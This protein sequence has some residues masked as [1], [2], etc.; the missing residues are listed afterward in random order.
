[1]FN[2]WI[3]ISVSCL[4]SICWV[5]NSF[6]LF[7]FI[8]ILLLL[9]YF[10]TYNQVLG[11]WCFVATIVFSVHYFHHDSKNVTVIPKH[12]TFLVGK[13]VTN[14]EIDGNQ[15]KMII[16][17]VKKEKVYLTYKIRSEDEKNTLNVLA[18]RSVCQF[19]VNLH[20][21]QP[22][23]NYNSFDFQKHLYYQHIHWIA[24]AK[25]INLSS[26]KSNG[27]GII[28]NLY[29]I[30]DKGIEVLESGF[31]SPINGYSLALIF[32]ERKLLA[33]STIDAYQQLGLIHILAISGMH[34]GL[35]C[36]FFY[37]IGIRIGIT[38]EKIILMLM[39]L[40]PLY[41]L[42][43][44]ATPSV[45]RASIMTMLLLLKLKFKFRWF[46]VLDLIS[47]AFILMILVN[48]Y[49]VFN[50]GFQLSF[51][52]SVSLI[53]SSKL[54]LKR[55][56]HPILQLLSVST[57]AQICS[58]PIILFHFYQFSF[59]SIILNLLYVPVISLLVL[60]ICIILFLFHITLPKI[61]IVFIQFF[62]YFVHFLDQIALYFSQ[63]EWHYVVL[64]KP[65]NGLL[66][67]YT[68]S[69]FYLLV[70]I[71]HPQTNLKTLLWKDA[72]FREVVGEPPQR[73]SPV[74]SH[75]SRYSCIA[76][77]ST[78]FFNRSQF[79][80]LIT[81]FLPFF[82]VLSLDRLLPYVN[83]F[84]E[85]TVMDVGQGDCI[86]VELPFR[87]EVYLIDTGGAIT[88][89]IEKWK[90]QKEQISIAERVLIPYLKSKGI[91][92]INKIFLTHPD[93]DHIGEA[94]TLLRHLEVEEINLPGYRQIT[95]VEQKI[96]E[97]AKKRNVMVQTI[98]GEQQWN[99][100][101]IPFMILSPTRSY[102]NKND[103]SIV[104]LTMFGKRTWLFT[105]D[106]EEEA[107][108][109]LIS[110]YPNLKVDVL[111]VAHHGSNTSTKQFFLDKITPKFAIFSV[112][113]NNHYGH[114]HVD[115]V[116]RLENVRI[117]RTD[118]NG[119]IRY[120]FLTDR[121]GTFQV[122]IPYDKDEKR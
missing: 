20:R 118:Q 9:I 8:L 53:L 14:P 44:G 46:S 65:S 3:Y 72:D 30:R 56:T 61:S 114:P 22:A 27:L 113:R 40:I 69:I 80:V 108:R 81:A 23:N 33:K 38:K 15:L 36:A 106:I 74:W 101:G 31:P 37:Y 52:V 19:E 11:L 1:L 98:R 120:R 103:S 71:E 94:I 17:T 76:N 79:K 2:K 83:P 115:V 82:V 119:A 50:V 49:Y 12:T 26:C 42:L 87:R 121:A 28:D 35:I 96:V 85:V 77:I 57:V 104:L 116:N 111:K 6:S 95:K 90:V 32:G 75:L 21:P 34:V 110:N 5:S 102:H 107:E 92:K 88:Y 41:C 7:Y 99:V 70:R 13:V 84:G 67:L 105:G 24:K 25:K 93:M 39:G 51:A 47:I 73:F 29:L 16:Q 60:P 68:I 78:L 58:T 109:T 59:I 117:L 62:N 86:V 97:V 54:I 100:N 10:S 122:K 55:F 66:L 48:P 112:G 4:L 91:N 45:I 64:G 89:N 18:S 63:I 43:A